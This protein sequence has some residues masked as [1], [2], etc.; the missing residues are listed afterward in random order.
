M[1]IVVSEFFY[2]TH[3][4]TTVDRQGNDRGAREYP[5]SHL[6]SSKYNSK[7]LLEYRSVIFY[8]SLEQK[9]IA[10]RVT[11]EVQKE[12]FDPK[13]GKIV[14]E[15]LEAGQWVDAEEYHQLYLLKN[16]TGYQ[17]YTHKLHW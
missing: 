13:E 10:Q 12:H 14:T 9:D 8:N 15:I 1:L 3:D 5:P 7:L 11:D 6:L 4:P 17:C 2:R 16:P